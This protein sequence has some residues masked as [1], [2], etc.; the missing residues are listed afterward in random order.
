MKKK[1][2]F[3]GIV[4]CIVALG[5]EIN[6]IFENGLKEVEELLFSLV[7]IAFWIFLVMHLFNGI[8]L[9]TEVKKDWFDRSQNLTDF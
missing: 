9:N 4:L 3:A 1:L 8:Y 6:L 2:L 7:L 5:T